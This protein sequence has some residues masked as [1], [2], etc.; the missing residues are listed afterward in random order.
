[1][2]AYEALE[3]RFARISAIEGALGILH[4]DTRTMMPE[5]SAHE[6]KSD[7]YAYEY[8]PTTHIFGD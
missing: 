6:R 1:M 3:A 8:G 7:R 4:W 5:G 2:Q